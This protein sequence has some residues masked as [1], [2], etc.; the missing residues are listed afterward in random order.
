MSDCSATS[1]NIVLDISTIAKL[2]GGF[3]FFTQQTNEENNAVT[4]GGV[5][6]QQTNKI[7]FS[8]LKPSCGEGQKYKNGT[9]GKYSFPSFET[10]LLTFIYLQVISRGIM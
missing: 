4:L 5:D 3:F 2:Y 7:H 1:N 9:C 10:L 8:D 6:L